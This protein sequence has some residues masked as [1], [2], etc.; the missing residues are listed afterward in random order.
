MVSQKD[1]LA[2][3]QLAGRYNADRVLLFGSSAV[4]HPEADDIDLGVEGIAAEDFFRF[5]GELMLALSKAVDLVDLSRDTR[6]TR[7][8][9]QHGTPVYERSR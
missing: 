6:F 3:R 9:K 8:I 1:S 5:Y 7:Q 2:I 4:G